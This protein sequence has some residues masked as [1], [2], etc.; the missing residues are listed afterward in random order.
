[1]AVAAKKI[2]PVALAAINKVEAA[3]GQ[4]EGVEQP[5]SRNEAGRFQKG[6]S[7]NPNGK[8]RIPDDIRAMLKAA[9]PQALKL[10]IDTVNNEGCKQDLRLKAADS[11]LDRVYGKATQPIEADMT[12]SVLPPAVSALTLEELRAL[13]LEGKKE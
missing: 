10:L 9:A 2:G 5:A 13:I 3:K 7:G 12:G 6:V 1:M 11:L 8:A 4:V